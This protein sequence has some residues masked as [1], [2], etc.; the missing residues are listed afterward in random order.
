MYFSN[1]SLLGTELSICIFYSF[2]L[3]FTI[4]QGLYL[5]LHTITFK[6][7]LYI[8]CLKG[9]IFDDKDY[10]SKDYDDR[11]CYDGKNNQIKSKKEI[12]KFENDFKM[13]EFD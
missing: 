10:Y 11:K 8:L 9:G 12:E 4:L 5:Y 13:V 6:V 1:S 2:L 3:S 7:L